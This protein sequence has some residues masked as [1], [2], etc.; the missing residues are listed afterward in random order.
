MGF[1]TK[2]NRFWTLRNSEGGF[3]LVELVVVIAILAILAGVAVPAYTGYI[4]KAREA[5]DQLL[6]AAVNEAFV[7]SCLEAGV[8]MIEVSE[9]KV[10]VVSQCVFGVSSVTGASDAELNVICSTFSQLFEGNFETAFVTENV[11]SLYW[12][13]DVSSF[14]MDHTTGVPSRV[15]LSN[16]QYATITAEDIDAISNSTY[17]QM[18]PSEVTA[19]INK[20]NSSGELLAGVA[21]PLGKFNGFATI[22]VN[23]GYMEQSEA[24][25]LL[26]T[27][28]NPLS[29]GYSD[30]LNTAA[31]GL[32]LYAAE[33][34]S[35]TTDANI[36]SLATQSLGSNSLELGTKLAGA[37]GS[38]TT[39]AL[40]IQYALV[41]SYAEANPDATVTVKDWLGREK[42][43]NVQAYLAD[44]SDPVTAINTIRT[45]AGFQNDY[46]STETDS[47]YQ[48][49]LAGFVS[50]MTVVGN[51]KEAIGV[52]EYLDNGINSAGAQ[53][54]LNA[55]L[56]SQSA[57]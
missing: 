50:T 29:S 4:K 3:T 31:N 34:I 46:Y 13:K 2:W 16:N 45:S 40:A 44:A 57:S 25:S 18:T 54:L 7:S 1:K 42:T 35:G 12:D 14:K 56:A 32:Q 38:Q 22:M 6:I 37:S 33:Y 52:D 36:Q 55:L 20:M 49:D 24:D 41:Q 26:A 21:A 51:N 17:S 15:L 11:K 23:N 30:A 48:K 39:A 19:I 10:S 9:A 43:Y 53:D 8:E 5:G 28:K 47:Q 27:L